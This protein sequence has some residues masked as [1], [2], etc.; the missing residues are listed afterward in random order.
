[1]DKLLKSPN[2]THEEG[3]GL[4]GDALEAIVEDLEPREA[5]VKLRRAPVAINIIKITHNILLVKK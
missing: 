2:C 3:V 5:G 1:M 4:T